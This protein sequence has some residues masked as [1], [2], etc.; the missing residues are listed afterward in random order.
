MNKMRVRK[1]ERKRSMTNKK[2]GMNL[3]GY[4]RL[5]SC[6]TYFLPIQIKDRKEGWIVE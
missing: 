5:T 2:D 1:I 6:T 3:K 4:L